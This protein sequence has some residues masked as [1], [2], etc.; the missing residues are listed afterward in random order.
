M[1]VVG[2][3]CV[4]TPALAVHGEYLEGNCSL[5]ESNLAAHMSP[6]TA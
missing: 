3:G 4:K 6:D 1:S 5:S 2:L